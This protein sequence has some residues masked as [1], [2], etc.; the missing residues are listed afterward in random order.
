MDQLSN[1]GYLLFDIS[2]RHSE[3][4]VSSK[5][6][7]NWMD[8]V[9]WIK[10]HQFYDDDPP[11]INLPFDTRL[12]ICAILAVSFAIGS[13]FKGITYMFVFFGDNTESLIK[14]PITTLILTSTII[15]H[16]THGWLVIWY[17]LSLMNETSLGDLLHPNWCHVTQY[18]GCYG[19]AYL[20]VGSL[21]IA[22]YRVLYIRNDYL[23]KYVIGEQILLMM[24]WTLSIVACGVITMLFNI[25]SSSQRF[26]VN[27]CKGISGT[28]EQ[29]MI[30]Y[31]VYHDQKLMPT[32]HLQMSAILACLTC[33]TIEFTIYVWFFNY[34]YQNDNGN[35]SKLLTED[36]IR[37]RNRK[38]I[39]TFVG[40]FYGF[41]MEYS[42][43]ILIF[44]LTFFG[45]VKNNHTKAMI[46]M[47][48]YVD[49][50]L[51]SAVEVL[52]SP[53]L[54]AFLWRIIKGD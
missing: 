32:T 51:L 44:F 30:E 33:Q 42:F 39:G 25:E 47:I 43:L 50:G 38:N 12:G 18:V 17:I 41:L 21:G 40:Q 49:F 7:T 11:L 16:V 53:N 54:R 19:I 10:I 35:I 5:S 31:R 2:N 48:K 3:S 9:E 27:M 8:D 52:S 4:F 1:S 37:S 45:D 6:S 26:Q 36:V 14:R 15:H 28:H 13:F 46:N 24:I 34:R 22:I 23:V 29:I 20:S